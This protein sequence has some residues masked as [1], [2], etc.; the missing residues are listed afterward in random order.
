MQQNIC[1]PMTGHAFAFVLCAALNACSTKPPPQAPA[2]PPAK[3]EM[4]GLKAYQAGRQAL[5]ANDSEAALKQFKDA[6][7]LNT[8]FTE[9]WYEVGRLEVS[10]APSLAKSDELKALVLFREGLQ[11]EQQA[12]RLLDEGKVRIWTPDETDAARVRL[13]SDLRD[14]DHVLAD[15]D[16]LREAL[17]M[18]VY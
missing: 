10:I 5:A 6:V 9:A 15:E 3:V 8:S 11:F 1:K 12:R 7:H 14:A 13:E 4:V 16:A 17:R 18:R 2:P